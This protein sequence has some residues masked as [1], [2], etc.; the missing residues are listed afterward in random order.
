M[1]SDSEARQNLL[2]AWL[3]DQNGELIAQE[4]GRF[5]A[6]IPDKGYVLGISLSHERNVKLWDYKLNAHQSPP[7]PGCFHKRSGIL[8]DMCRRV[9]R[10]QDGKGW[11]DFLRSVARKTIKELE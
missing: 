11:S 5:S 6:Y 7:Y 3:K 8:V 2:H 1:S 9:D 4:E 10:N